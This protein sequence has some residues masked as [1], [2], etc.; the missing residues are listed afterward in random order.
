MTGYLRLLNANLW[1]RPLR[2]CF[3]LGSIVVAFMM[4]GVLG[5][6]TRAFSAGADLAGADRLLVTH[7]VSLVQALPASYR[8]R[9]RQVDGVR[10]V[11]SA[12]WFG[13]IYQDDR[14][15]LATFP[16][17]DEEYLDIYP[18]YVVDPEGRARWMTDRRGAIVGR[19][20][21]EQYG[22]KLGDTIPLRSNIWRRQDDSDAWEL[23]VSAIYDVPEAGGDPRNI[24]LHYDYFNE[25]RGRG[26]DLVNWYVVQVADPARA[27]GIAREIDQQFANSPY[28]TKTSTEKAFAQGFVNQIGNIGALMNYV[29]SAVFF[30]MLLVTANTMAQSVRERVPEIG[31]LKTLGFSG[32]RVTGLV[33]A[34]S[35]LLTL[36][37]AA[38]GMA[39]A[40]ALVE[41][42]GEVVRRYLPVWSVPAEAWLDGL[43]IALLL[44]LVAG[45]VPALQ[46]LRLPIVRA[47]RGH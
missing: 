31:V 18:E 5:A 25:S 43:G 28:E 47:L 32:S 3:T 36:L 7:K 41:G 45:A 26:K 40:G 10:R 20:L 17:D 2:T 6:M 23:K 44:G 1:R 24:L 14:N 9:I 34:E 22:W 46:A 27:P 42:V 11:S 15:Q 37:G 13:G 30:T 21:A 8:Q 4:F 29:V 33:L 16:V 38:A 39:A 35:C 19:P 12:T